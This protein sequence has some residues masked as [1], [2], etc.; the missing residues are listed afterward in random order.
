MPQSRAHPV[1]MIRVGTISET[2]GFVLGVASAFR[3][4]LCQLQGIEPEARHYNN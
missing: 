2:A 4:D 1:E 3:S